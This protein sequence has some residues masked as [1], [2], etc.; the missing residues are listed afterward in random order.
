VPVAVW[1]VIGYIFF[2]LFLL[3]ASGKMAEKKRVWPLLFLVSFA[4][5]SVSIIYAFISMYYIHS[6]CIMCIVIFAINFLLLFYV[7][8]I[9]RRFER[10]GIL[11]GLR[12]D[13]GF[14]WNVR[15]KCVSL[16]S[17]FM[18]VVILTVIFFPG[19][20]NFAPPPLSADITKGI[21]E[22]GH[23]WIG[24]KNPRVIITE[25]TDYMCFQCKKMHFYLRQLVSKYPD[26]I[27]LVHYHYPMDDEFNPI[28]VKK[29][30]HI[31]SGKLSLL[32]IYAG[33]KDKF[34]EMND[35]LFDIALKNENI[36]LRKLAKK[37]GLDFRPL[38]GSINDPKMR[39]RLQFDVWKGMKLRV[40]GTPSYVIDGRVYPG[41]VPPEIIKQALR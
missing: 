29:P 41:H 19:Y 9:R 8:L 4:F 13:I 40:I 1:G 16:F 34:W 23:P 32:A 25:F 14:L 20:W 24:A 11:D 37:V 39:Y 35:L 30:F 36:N 22:D 17:P 27:R 2:L 38:A 33:S 6:Y 15:K 21:T 31:G 3:F 18:L 12:C 26:R 7:W 10:T 5:S 28:V